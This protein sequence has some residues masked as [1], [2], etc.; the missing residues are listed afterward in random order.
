M[1]LN[2]RNEHEVFKIGVFDSNDSDAPASDNK[3]AGEVMDSAIEAYTEAGMRGDAM[4]IALD[5]MDVEEKTADSLADLVEIACLD[6]SDET[7]FDD[8]SEEEPTIDADEYAEMYKFVGDALVELGAKEASVESLINEDDDDA[9][10]AVAYQI[11]SVMDEADEADVDLIS[12]FAVGGAI[13]DDAEKKVIRNGEVSFISK[14]KRK[15]RLSATQRAAMKKMR[16]KAHKSGARKKRAK[17]MKQRKARG[18][19]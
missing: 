15:K 3:L 7:I 16:L 12:R 4:A 10:E 5:W 13:F 8:D 1:Q 14:K 18:M 17:S 19:K 9:A 6:E 11:E 2:T